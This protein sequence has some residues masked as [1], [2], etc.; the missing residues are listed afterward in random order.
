MPEESS[1]AR[2]QKGRPRTRIAAV[3]PHCG[4]PF[5]YQP[6][7]M[8]RAVTKILYCK[9]ACTY[10][11]RVGNWTRQGWTE[12]SK[13]KARQTIRA[14]KVGNVRMRHGYREVMTP[15]GYV[16]EH[17]L[18][19]AR[20]IGRPLTSE[21]IV[22]HINHVKTDNRPDNLVILTSSEHCTVHITE[23]VRSSEFLAFLSEINTGKKLSVETRAKMSARRQGSLHPRAKLHEADIPD[24]LDC[25]NKGE[26]GA[27]VAR[28]YSVGES[29]ISRIKTRAGWTHA[30]TSDDDRREIVQRSFDLH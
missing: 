8:Q 21:E 19:M 22:H 27:S 30:A 9:A 10:A 4:S 7:R 20:L 26:S 12:E 6:H 5:E 3:C 14:N 23:R 29:T 2:T 1:T 24:I 16:L 17:R 25:L 11:A 13:A 28:R 15:D 18:V